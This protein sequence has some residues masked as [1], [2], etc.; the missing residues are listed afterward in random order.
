MK[1][2]WTSRDSIWRARELGAKMRYKPQ[3]AFLS[4]KMM[5]TMVF[6]CSTFLDRLKIAFNDF[7][8]T[9]D[10]TWTLFW[11]LREPPSFEGVLSLTLAFSLMSTYTC[12]QQQPETCGKWWQS[13]L[14]PVDSLAHFHSIDGLPW[15]YHG[16]LTVLTHRSD[17]RADPYHG[18]CEIA[19]FF[20][21]FGLHKIP[22]N[23]CQTPNKIDSKT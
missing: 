19:T 4:T 7:I 17:Y 15:V 8:G 21:P 9:D 23:F 11:R 10:R 18:F 16:V 6:R 22:L 12:T 14:H 2:K 5:Q 1:V 3:I 20:G 13:L